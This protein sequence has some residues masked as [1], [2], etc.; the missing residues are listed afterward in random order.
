MTTVLEYPCGC[1][2]FSDLKNIRPIHMCNDHKNQAFGD[3]LIDF[4]SQ[5]FI[6]VWV[7]NAFSNENHFGGYDTGENR[8]VTMC[9]LKL[10]NPVIKDRNKP[11]C[12]ICSS[13]IVH[14]NRNSKNNS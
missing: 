7:T 13:Q 3:A 8:I 14:N 2:Y 6:H 11:E 12:K 10:D 1:K 9:M 5:N 4:A